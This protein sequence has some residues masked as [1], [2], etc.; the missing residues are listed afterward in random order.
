MSNGLP[1]LSYVNSQYRHSGHL[2][3]SEVGLTYFGARYYAPMLG[4]WIS[5]D[6]LR[7]HAM[8]GDLNPY[9]FVAGSPLR[10]V[11]PVGFDECDPDITSCEGP[12]DCSDQKCPSGEGP[13]YGGGGGGGGRGSGA[14]GGSRGSGAPPT[15]PPNPGVPVKAFD[16]VTGA[17]A[18]ATGQQNVQ[19]DLPGGNYLNTSRVR[20][21]AANALSAELVDALLDP[22]HAQ[23]AVPNPLASWLK[24]SLRINAGESG[25]GDLSEFFGKAAV[26]AGGF[27]IGGPAEDAPIASTELEGIALKAGETAGEGYHGHHIF[28][29]LKAFAKYWKQ[30]G[31]DIH[32]FRVTLLEGTHLDQ[33]HNRSVFGPG[34]IWNATWKKFFADNPGKT[35]TEDELFIQAS[36]MLHTFRIPYYSPRP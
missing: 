35:F 26:F 20:I 22:F 15:P 29:Q 36:E 1:T 7:I 3:D 10:F 31:I 12:P 13:G 17:V 9:G 28:P 23:S 14:T 5:P 21:A 4:R 6:P 32:N 8:A 2:D 30:A 11:D 16:S 24:E 19:V 34:G 18:L 25:E 33:L 27:L